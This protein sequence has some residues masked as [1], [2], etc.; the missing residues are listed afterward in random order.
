MNPKDLIRSTKGRFFKVVFTRK[1]GTV[2]VM[3]ARLGVQKNLTGQGLAFNPSDYNLMT[4]WD[5]Q[6]RAYRMLNLGTLLSF[7]SGKLSWQAA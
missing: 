5:V 3:I 7:R 6:K 4:V 1:D 2:R